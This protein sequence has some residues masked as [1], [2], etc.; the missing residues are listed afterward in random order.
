[1]EPLSIAE[2]EP[3]MPEN[4]APDKVTV[5]LP[6]DVIERV[7]AKAVEDGFRNRADWFRSLIMDALDTE[8]P[9]GASTDEEI[10]NIKTLLKRTHHRVRMVE[11]RMYHENH[12]LFHLMSCILSEGVYAR[13]ASIAAATS[14]GFVD[15]D[16][17]SGEVDALMMHAESTFLELDEEVREQLKRLRQEAVVNARGLS[18]TSDDAIAGTGG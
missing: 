9:S 14:T 11:S 1:M 13:V 7:D 8:E 17:V 10:A 3:A 2:M 6:Q 4:T 5:R 16:E 12:A 15:K 18:D